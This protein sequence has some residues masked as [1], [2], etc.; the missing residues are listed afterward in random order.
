LNWT[1]HLEA[2]GSSPL[3]TILEV[4]HL[5]ASASHTP[6]SHTVE[7]A[8]WSAPGLQNPSQGQ[9]QDTKTDPKVPESTLSW[10]WDMNTQ[11]Q[12]ILE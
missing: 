10:P 7:E 3:F 5:H 2:R 4:P 12:R 6:L 11:T 9:E 1:F 8:A